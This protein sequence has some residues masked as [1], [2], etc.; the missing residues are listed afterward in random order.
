LNGK[1]KNGIPRF[2][3]T[4]KRT[5]KVCPACDPE[6]I[7]GKDPLCKYHYKEFQGTVGLDN[8]DRYRAWCR[9]QQDKEMDV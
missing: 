9:V 4:K 1:N 7:P 3:V 6:G 8:L 5:E 2:T